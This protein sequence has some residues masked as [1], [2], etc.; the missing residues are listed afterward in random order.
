MKLHGIFVCNYCIFNNGRQAA[1]GA[2]ILSQIHRD[3]QNRFCHIFR[4]QVRAIRKFYPLLNLESIGFSIFAHRPILGQ[5]TYNL[6]VRIVLKQ[7]IVKTGQIIGNI[8]SAGR[9]NFWGDDGIEILEVPAFRQV[10][11]DRLGL[12][13]SL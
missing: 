8:V 11:M 1:I 4:S 10:Q 12:C 3:S 2:I 7:G 13:I 5:Y 6:A 9:G